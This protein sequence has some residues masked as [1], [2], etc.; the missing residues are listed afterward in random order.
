MGHGAGTEVAAA[1]LASGLRV[2]DMADPQAVRQAAWR[3]PDVPSGSRLVCSKDLFVDPRRLIYL[4][5]RNRAPSV[6]EWI[7]RGRRCAALWRAGFGRVP[8][9]WGQS[10]GKAARGSSCH[11]HPGGAAGQAVP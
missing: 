4:V 9:P 7:K 1:W 2:I 8:E 5:D 10:A 11:I 3:M 6:L